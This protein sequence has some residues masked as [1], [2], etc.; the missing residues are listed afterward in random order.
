MLVKMNRPVLWLASRRSQ[1]T[2]ISRTAPGRDR[3][4]FC[5]NRLGYYR[6]S[7]RCRTERV[8]VW[9]FTLWMFYVLEDCIMWSAHICPSVCG[10]ANVLKCSSLLFSGFIVIPKPSQLSQWNSSIAQRSC[11][12]EVIFGSFLLWFWSPWAQEH[13][14]VHQCDHGLSFH[15]P[16]VFIWYGFTLSCISLYYFS[17]VY[18]NPKVWEVIESR[19]EKQSSLNPRSLLI[20]LF[21]PSFIRNRFDPHC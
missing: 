20:V 11:R 16:R 12:S 15:F 9:T 10:F 14:C 6:C 19:V 2:I 21:S 13:V 5:A 3:A 1:H 18:F 17:L 7:F 8:C 4:L